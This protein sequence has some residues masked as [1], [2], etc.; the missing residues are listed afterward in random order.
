MAEMLN[1]FFSS[2]FT[3]ED[4]NN[5]PDAEA[6]IVTRAMPPVQ[7]S[8]Q[9]V[10]KKIRELRRDAAA[11]PDDSRWKSYSTSLFTL[12]RHP[13]TGKQRTSRPYSRRGSK[14]TQ[15]TIDQYL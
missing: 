5:V 15:A 3:K 1:Q 9:D 10:A 4:L 7:V 13:Q 11:G 2:V 14:E 8:E 12:E 6:E